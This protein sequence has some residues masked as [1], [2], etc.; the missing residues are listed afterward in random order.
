MLLSCPNCKEVLVKTNNET[1][2]LRLHYAEIKI[3]CNS[4]GLTITP[5]EGKIVNNLP[6]A[7]KADISSD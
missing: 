1:E 4:C 5:T 2:G 3:T 6:G 7:P